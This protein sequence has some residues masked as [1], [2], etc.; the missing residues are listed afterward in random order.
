MKDCWHFI[1]K[2][3]FIF[4]TRGSV[5]P[6]EFIL[7]IGV[8]YPDPNG[9]REYEGV[10]YSKRIDEYGEEWIK[11]Y[12]PEYIV[13]N[14]SGRQILVPIKDVKKYFDPFKI[15]LEEKDFVRGTKWGKLIETLEKL[16][17][18]ED[19]GFI[20]S[21]LIGFP[22]ENTDIDI[23]IRGVDNLKKIKQNFDII[24]KQLSATDNIGE[25]LTKISLEKYENLYVKEKNN[26]SK[27]IK[28]RWPTI[29]TFEY[30]T[31]LR[32]IPREGEIIFPPLKKK[33]KEIEI[34][35][36]VIEDI[37]TN[38]M[39]RFF[40]IKADTGE[41]SVITYFWDYTY[42]VKKNDKVMINGSLFEDNVISLNNR[43]KHGINFN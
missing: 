3:G 8:Y 18:T 22:S 14:E 4:T 20:G 2:D 32:F 41:Y 42:C 43:N 21:R 26:F 25:A 38:F 1:T 10:K 7:S 24:L 11:Q 19:I 36:R 6:K 37:G 13:Q 23:V 17:P 9:N 16:I 5:H 39:P 40:K 15:S 28:N 35:G 29:K 33:L 34:K 27:M 30:M 31:K 12:R